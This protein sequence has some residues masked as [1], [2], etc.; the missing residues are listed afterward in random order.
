[1]STR[2]VDRVELCVCFSPLYQLVRLI[3]WGLALSK[4]TVDGGDAIAKMV[5][6]VGWIP[7]RC[8]WELKGLSNQSRDRAAVT[9]IY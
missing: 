8:L 5:K 1:M 4:G 7:E 3:V 6:K 2:E 9:L